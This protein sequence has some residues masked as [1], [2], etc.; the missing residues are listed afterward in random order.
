MKRST[1]AL[2]LTAAIGSVASA[3][4]SMD[5]LQVTQPDFRGTARFM[6]MGGAFTA[7]GG[8]MSTMTQNPAGLGVYRHSEI[9]ATLDI[10]IQNTKAPGAVGDI[11]NSKT[12]VDC[13]NFG[14][15]GVAKLDNDMMPF[16]NWGVAYNRRSSFDRTYTAYAPTTSTSLTN[17][18]A[19]FTDTPVSDL[20]FG[21]NYN[22]YQESDADW[23]S[24]LGA[25]SHLIN[26]QPGS[27]DSYHGLF[28]PGATNGDASLR[29]RE[30]GYVDDYNIN[31]AGNIYDVVYWGLGVG[32]SDL[33]YRR[34]TLY[35][36]SMENAVAPSKVYGGVITDADAGFELENFKDIR[37]SGWNLSFGLIVKPIHELRFGASVV[38]PTY[39]SLDHDYAGAVSYSY[40][41]PQYP[42]SDNNPMAGVEETDYA[43]FSWK[44][45]SPWRFMVGASAVIGQNAIISIDYERQAY[46]DMT[47]K[48]AV[49]GRY[50]YLDS[51]EDNVYVNNDVRNYCQGANIV[52]IGAEYRVT[53]QFSVR[54][55]YN[56]T[57]TNVKDEVRDGGTEVVTSG[58]DPSFSFTKTN[59][60]ICLG[61][62]YKF[63][64]FYL[65]GAYV[66]NHRTSNMF[67]FTDSNAG[68]APMWKVSD[69]NSSIVM[70]LGFRF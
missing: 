58:T 54:A 23:L 3:Q 53:P 67:A 55:G 11:K 41:D 9:A 32:I 6:S 33:S 70:T 5:M 64:S 52:R 14:Y 69:N 45:R 19:S 24:I 20:L 16:F 34:E 39:W 65:D 25:T 28:Q 56:V 10:N 43:S 21:S 35:T 51:Y 60:N 12:K 37:G 47:M 26:T 36:E 30:R 59:E 49:Y 46:N 31:F 1:I 62:G 40:F 44:L 42:E 18:I 8:D 63:K 2:A 66:Y 38:S 29:V 17:Y 48:S 22:P 27:T 61:L 50:G 4:S 57:G 15:V 7:L 13:N 68:L